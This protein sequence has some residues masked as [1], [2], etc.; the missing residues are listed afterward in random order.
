MP[1]I[2]WTPKF[3]DSRRASPRP[4]S[5]SGGIRCKMVVFFFS[6]LHLLLLSFVLNLF[7]LEM[8]IVW[9][10]KVYVLVFGHLP[11][12]YEVQNFNPGTAHLPSGTRQQCYG[13]PSTTACDLQYPNLQHPTSM[14]VCT[15]TTDKLL[16]HY[17][18]K[19]VHNNHPK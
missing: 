7:S 9:E 12:R 5:G 14:Y 6:F 1:G 13:I 16:P 19:H 15:G 3:R 11:H 2:L 8:T 4:E 17:E 18:L 10:P